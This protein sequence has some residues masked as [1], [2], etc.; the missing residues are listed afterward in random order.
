MID[1]REEQLF[2]KVMNGVDI[3]YESLFGFALIIFLRD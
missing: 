3:S 1:I 2:L